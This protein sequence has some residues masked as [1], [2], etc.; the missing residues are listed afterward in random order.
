M[1]AVARISRR[2][3]GLPLAI[4]L[5]AARVKMMSVEQIASRLDDALPLLKANMGSELPHHQTLQAAIDW[6]YSLLSE[7]E[8][9]LLRRLSVFA[10]GFTLEAAEQAT[11]LQSDSGPVD[12][13][14]YFSPGEVLDLLSNL[15]DKSL[16]V[17][18]EDEQPSEVRYRLLEIVNQYARKRLAEAAELELA[19]RQHADFFLA[20]AEEAAPN[21]RSAQQETWLN[22]LELENDNL[23]AALEW[24]KSLPG[25][26]ELGLR[27]AASLW[28]YWDVRG[29]YSEG[30]QWLEEILA[31]SPDRSILRAKALKAAG[32]LAWGQCDYIPARSLLTESLAIYQEFG[33]KQDIAAGTLNLGILSNSQG[34]YTSAIPLFQQS[35]AIFREIGHQQ[36][37]ANVLNSLGIWYSDQGDY[38]RA[39]TYLEESLVLRREMGDK[40]GVAIVLGNLGVVAWRQDDCLGARP[41]LQESLD[42]YQEVGDKRG[43]GTSLNELGRVA[44]QMGELD[45]AHALFNESLAIWQEMGNKEGIATFLEGSG[46]LACSW[47]NHA[48]AAR[49]LS[50]AEALRERAGS[51]VAPADQID[52]AHILDNLRAALTEDQLAA[53]WA[54]G[55]RISLEKAV[56]LAVSMQPLPDCTG[57]P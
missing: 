8:Q 1:P 5:A 26:A 25:G 51:P 38:A 54:E 29:Y 45:L 22:R 20:M 42:L 52:Q 9:A 55:R 18:V 6:S 36:G 40:R 4:E 21:L 12:F 24:S 27:L 19:R 17:V 35:L 23:R 43:A 47:Y 30:R 37:I 50:A 46:G 16:V 11:T 49:L 32:A 39:R 10:G 48:L 34:D 28:Q 41:L 3:E 14:N 2:L 56:D 13:T 53:L 15:I 44:H 7:K 33:N 57:T 31:K